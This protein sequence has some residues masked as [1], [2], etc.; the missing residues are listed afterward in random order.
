MQ[1]QPY[2]MFE[3]RGD[4]AIAFY[5]KALGAELIMRMRVKE[6]PDPHP[7]GMLPPGSEDKILHASLR[8]GS[9]EVSLSDGMC[10]GSPTFQGISLSLTVDTVEEADRFFGALAEGGNVHMPLSETFFSPRFGM[11]ADR[12]GVSWMVY[13]EPKDK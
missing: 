13:V 4:E 9:T 6:S 5:Q 7:P 2:L 3:G 1:V 10:A 8:I 12:F 11:L